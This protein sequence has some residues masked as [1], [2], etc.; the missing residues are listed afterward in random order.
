VRLTQGLQAGDAKGTEASRGSGQRG[1]LQLT[2]PTSQHMCACIGISLA[3]PKTYPPHIAGR[4]SASPELQEATCISSTLIGTTLTASLPC[5]DSVLAEP[6]CN[7]CVDTLQ[8][9]S[10]R[11]LSCRRQPWR[12]CWTCAGALASCTQSTSHVTAGWSAGGCRSK[13]QR[14]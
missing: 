5:H 3:E 10:L 8:A 11:V 2:L 4:E 1:A 14:A 9:V 6:K 12:A 13:Q 7:A